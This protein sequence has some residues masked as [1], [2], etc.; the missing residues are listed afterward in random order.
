MGSASDRQ[1]WPASWRP[2]G[3]QGDIRYPTP[4]EDFLD[5][6]TDVELSAPRPQN[7]DT[8]PFGKVANLI[9]DQIQG[10]HRTGYT[11]TKLGGSELSLAVNDKL[12]IDLYNASSSIKQLAPLLLYLRYRAAPNQTLIID[13]P[14]MNLHPEGQAK[15]LEAL[16]M[17]A[18]LGVHVLLT[19]HSPYSHGPSQQ[20]DCGRR[21]KSKARKARQ[22][23]HLYMGDPAA[24][25]SPADVS[26]YEMRTEGLVSLADPEYGIRW[27]TLSDVSAELQRR[28]FAIVEEP[29]GR[30]R[31]K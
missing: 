13:E 5:F 16:A 12:R 24:F 7:A 30:T 27:D 6:L 11:Q 10:G 4:I 23:K 15:L 22:A 2:P 9:E 21:A 17:L 18:N 29:R 25:L 14:E 28:Y 3:E 8:S 1:V 20:P 19:T 26:A 31:A